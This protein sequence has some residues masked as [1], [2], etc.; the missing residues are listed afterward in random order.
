M[1]GDIPIKTSTIPISDFLSC[2]FHYSLFPSPFRFLPPLVILV[3]LNEGLTT[4][5]RLVTDIH[6]YSNLDSM[7]A[8]LQAGTT[9]PGLDILLPFRLL[10]FVL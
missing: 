5:P 10:P 2:V 6:Q 3:V 1:G 7:R 9:T 4:E 8:G